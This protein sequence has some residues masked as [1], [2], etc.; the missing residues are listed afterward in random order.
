[1]LNFCPSFRPTLLYMFIY[2]SARHVV[3]TRNFASGEIT[4]MESW[5]SQ[6]SIEENNIT[7]SLKSSQIKTTMFMPAK[8][9]ATDRDIIN[10]LEVIN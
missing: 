5:G 3:Y 8:S 4:T 2:I 6:D 1:M 7:P 9:A 10:Y